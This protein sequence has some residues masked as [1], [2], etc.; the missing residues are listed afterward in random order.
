M[1]IYI[2]GQMTGFENAN[3]EAFKEAAERIKRAGQTPINPHELPPVQ[4]TGDA[5]KDWNLWMLRD[6]EYLLNDE[7]RPDAIFM[8]DGWRKSKG[9]LIEHA[10]AIST[11]IKVFASYDTLPGEERKITNFDALAES[12]ERMGTA[13]SS[14]A[15]CDNCIL[16]SKICDYRN[17]DNHVEYCKKNIMEW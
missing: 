13:L 7:T 16:N 3:S 11:G 6:M 4:T 9:A 14:L 15:P 12:I 8:I 10:L 5:E 17:Q 2:S 1:R